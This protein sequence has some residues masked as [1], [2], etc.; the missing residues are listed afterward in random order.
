MSF[1][2]DKNDREPAVA[3]SSINKNSSTDKDKPVSDKPK[4]SSA[5][6]TGRNRVGCI[7]KHV[8]EEEVWYLEAYKIQ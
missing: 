5:P 2:E 1:Q 8:L 3:S 7:K 4:I 6:V